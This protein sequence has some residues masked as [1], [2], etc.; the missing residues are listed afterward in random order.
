VAIFLVESVELLAV[1]P[2]AELPEEQLLVAQPQA[3]LPEEQLLVVR[4]RVD[5]P[6]EQLLVAHLQPILF[7]WLCVHQYNNQ[8]PRQSRLHLNHSGYSHQR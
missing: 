8:Q 2:Q 3:E 5:L 1:Q 4:P 7:Q 6:E